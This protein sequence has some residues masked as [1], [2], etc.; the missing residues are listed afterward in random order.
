M[1]YSATHPP[2]L[3]A[4]LFITLEHF[5]LGG[6]SSLL[7][8]GLR[9][10]EAEGR[11]VDSGAAIASVPRGSLPELVPASVLIVDH[12]YVSARLADGAATVMDARDP[13]FWTGAEQN[14]QNPRAGRIA[15]AVNLPFRT[16]VDD[17]GRFLP[18]AEID[19]LF[20]EAGVE[21]TDPVVTYCHVGQQASLLLFGAR[22]TGRDAQMYDGSFQDWSARPELPVET[23]P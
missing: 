21:Q 9:A 17:S 4:R 10:W 2:Q 19:R 16:L 6:R 22:L 23:G 18:V 7:D 8:G 20:S 3:A 14:S 15:G 1:I 13:Q 5:G 11:S 12:E